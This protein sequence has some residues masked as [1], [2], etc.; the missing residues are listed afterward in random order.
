MVKQ[1][2]KLEIRKSADYHNTVVETLEKAGF[3]VV[4]SAET[5]TDRYCIIAE[6]N[7]VEEGKDAL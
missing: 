7:N 2:G 5:T 3:V 4:L 1:L 6:S